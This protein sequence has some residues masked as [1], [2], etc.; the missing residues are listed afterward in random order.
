MESENPTET[1]AAKQFNDSCESD[2][3]AIPTT[4]TSDPTDNMYEIEPL[5]RDKDTE[6]SMEN[7]IA[8]TTEQLDN[9]SDD[10]QVA[11]IASND[12]A[13]EHYE[14]VANEEDD[15][16]MQYFQYKPSESNMA[17]AANDNDKTITE[18]EITDQRI[19]EQYET[20]V[21]DTV[22]Y[23]TEITQSVEVMTVCNGTAESNDSIM[24]ASDEF[25]EG[26]KTDEVSQQFSDTVVYAESREIS[27]SPT[28]ADDAEP[29]QLINGHDIPVSSLNSAEKQESIRSY[30]DGCRDIELSGMKLATHQVSQ[31]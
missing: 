25:F 6:W 5:E 3:R 28:K 9:A 29:T 21:T 18:M 7:S 31:K 19:V 2:M 17:E 4:D 23:R 27:N 11:H 20:T 13:A 15:K 22:V 24:S 14:N 8:A 12:I 30:V 10:E 26:R 16:T 1:V